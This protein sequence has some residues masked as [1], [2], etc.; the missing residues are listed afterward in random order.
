MKFRIVAVGKP[1]AQNVA[2]AIQDYETRAARYWP[3]EIREVR[4]E[5][6]RGTSPEQVREREGERLLAASGAG[7]LIVACEGDGDARSSAELAAWMTAE[8]ERA[9][10]DVAFIIG[11]ALG[12]STAVRAAASQRLSFSR[13][14]FPHEIARL[15][16]AEQLYRAGT[17][18]RGEPYH[19]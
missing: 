15:L 5:S 14:T 3:L 13:F 16:L 2:A 9:A 11:G 12:L 10:R 19:K 7:A 1:R 18:V 17:I 4:E 6:A 8:R